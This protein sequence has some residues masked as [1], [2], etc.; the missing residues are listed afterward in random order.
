MLL[1]LL[2]CQLAPSQEEAKPSAD[3]CSTRTAWSAELPYD[4]VDNDCN[5]ST[6]D[7]DL[8][9]DGYPSAEDCDDNNPEISPANN[10]LDYDGL[11]NDCS[12]VTPDDDLDADGYPEAGDCDD[13]DATISPSSPEL[14]YDGVDNDCSADTPDD[15]LDA[16]GYPAASECDDS[17]EMISP[18]LPELPYDSLDNDCNPTTPDDD[19]DADGYPVAED[20]DDRSA[21]VAPSLAEIAYD[22]LDNDCNPATPDDDEDGDGAASAADCDDRDARRFPG[23]TESC[24]DGVDQDCDGADAICTV[25]TN[26][27][28]YDVCSGYAPFDRVGAVW[29]WAGVDGRQSLSWTVT[30]TGASSFDGIDVWGIQISGSGSNSAATQVDYFEMDR[31]VSCETDGVHLVAE[32]WST[33]TVAQGNSSSASGL[34]RFLD[35]PLLVPATIARFGSWQL[36]G[37]QLATTPTTYTRTDA[38]STHDFYIPYGRYQTVDSQSYAVWRVEN[39]D[40]TGA[41]E[42]THIHN[43]YG[44]L[45][46]EYG[47]ARYSVTSFSGL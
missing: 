19:L 26:N 9:A 40:E 14:P 16:D 10:E 21:A 20:C 45:Y 42:Y 34:E 7:D 13:G 15:D 27:L 23:A 11:D 28:A 17:N 43:G 3:D 30:A 32:E 6:P 18:D 41:I 1:L 5:P 33:T 4:G 31:W 12:P 47:S 35:R 8:D 37:V 38:T 36:S 46:W 22:G 24:E 25:S 29:N 39:T 2:A 44:L